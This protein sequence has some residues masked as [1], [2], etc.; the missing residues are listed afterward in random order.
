MRSPGFVGLANR[1]QWPARGSD[2]VLWVR[3][4]QM[5]SETGKIFKVT[6]I[7]ST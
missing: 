7:F 6:V 5:N 4:V 1:V 3:Q 2:C